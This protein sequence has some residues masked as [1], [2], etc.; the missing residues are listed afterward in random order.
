MAVSPAP[1]SLDM[2]VTCTSGVVPMSTRPPA[3]TSIR[4]MSTATIARREIDVHTGSSDV[5]QVPGL[6]PASFSVGESVPTVELSSPPLSDQPV[7]VLVGR[8]CQP[9]SS[10]CR[11]CLNKQFQFRWGECVP[12][13]D[14]ISPPLSGQS[15]TASSQTLAW[16]MRVTRRCPCPP[17]VFRRGTPRT[18]RSRAVCFM[19][20]RFRRDFCLGHQGMLSSFRWMGYCCRRRWTISVTRT[21]VPR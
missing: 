1:P 13:V 5:D 7:P 16:G 19:Y 17:I 21:L 9:L 15:S 4:A 14:S 2:T 20:C 3:V 11:R 6:G 8:V 18:F 12:A 10:L